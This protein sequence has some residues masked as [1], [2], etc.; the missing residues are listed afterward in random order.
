MQIASIK[1]KQIQKIYLFVKL[2]CMVDIHISATAY[3]VLETIKTILNMLMSLQ[4][5]LGNRIQKA[6]VKSADAA[7]VH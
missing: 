1:L 6:R 3:P 5:G 7:I 4:A 2:G